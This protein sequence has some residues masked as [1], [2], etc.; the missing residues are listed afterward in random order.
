MELCA[1]IVSDTEL[2]CVLLWLKHA[3]ISGIRQP[4]AAMLLGNDETE[5]PQIPQA[6]NELGG[7]LRLPVPAF[8]VLLL[9]PQELIDGVDHHSQDLAVLVPQAR[10]R[11]QPILQD[12]ARHEIFCDAHPEPIL[13]LDQ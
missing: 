11:K 12:P 5:Q 9:G 6:L 10:I 7:L 4:N 13:L 8:E 1:P 3:G 2:S